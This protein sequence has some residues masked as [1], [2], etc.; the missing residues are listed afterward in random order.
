MV[1]IQSSQLRQVIQGVEFVEATEPATAGHR[2]GRVWRS[3]QVRAGDRHQAHVGRSDQSRLSAR[4][5]LRDLDR[6]E[7]QAA[8]GNLRVAARQ[9]RSL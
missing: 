9:I 2:G 5:R 4:R 8:R 3:P 6:S 1:P 7:Q